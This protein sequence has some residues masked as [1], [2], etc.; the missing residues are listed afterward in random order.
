MASH[1]LL[2]NLIIQNNGPGLYTTGIRILKD[3]VTIKD[4]N[5]Q[6]TPIGISIWSDNNTIHNCSFQYCSDEGIVLLGTSF[7]TANNNVISSCYFQQN[8]DAIE[9]QQ[10]CNNTI[11]DCVMINNTHSGIDAIDKKNDYNLIFNCTIAQNNVHGIYFT[12]SKDNQIINCTIEKNA[13]GD[14]MTPNSKNTTITTNINQYTSPLNQQF[15]IMIENVIINSYQ[16]ND[17][18]KTTILSQIIHII[19]T[20]IGSIILSS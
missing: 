4:C 13:N 16:P 2:S 8:C 1:V 18:Q 14:I 12:H 3:N 17:Y 9:L 19:K 10:S 7:S 11:K 15:L 6:N 20:I 5:F